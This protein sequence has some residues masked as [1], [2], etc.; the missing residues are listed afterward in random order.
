MSR[1]TTSSGYSR[2]LTTLGG[3][4]FDGDHMEIVENQRKESFSANFVKVNKHA[5]KALLERR[6][7]ND[8]ETDE[9]FFWCIKYQGIQRSISFCDRRS[10]REVTFITTE[11]I[12]CSQEGDAP[13]RRQRWARVNYG[14][15]RR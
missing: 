5:Y 12:P 8:E 7:D 1:L 3:N 6:I 14:G 2:M 4:D 10:S 13:L 11:E 15:G 9:E